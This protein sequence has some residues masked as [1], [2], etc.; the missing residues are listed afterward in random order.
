MPSANW[1]FPCSPRNPAK[2]RE[3]L[4]LLA[5]LVP[6]WRARGLPWSPRSGA[7]LEFGRR[8]RLMADDPP[9]PSPRSVGE[10]GG[11]EA[12]P[13]IAEDGPERAALRFQTQSPVLSDDH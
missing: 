5:A 13:P 9:S 2:L 12:L 4:R 1:S 8:L 10:P 3:E 11:E 7:Q 6:S